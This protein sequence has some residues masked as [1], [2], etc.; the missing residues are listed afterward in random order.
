MGACYSKQEDEDN[1]VGENPGTNL[2]DYQPQP[3][4][5]SNATYLDSRSSKV[6]GEVMISGTANDINHIPGASHIV[7]GG[8]QSQPPVSTE[9]VYQ[10]MNQ[11]IL[12][13]DV[14]FQSPLQ[15]GVGVSTNNVMQDSIN[16]QTQQ[17]Y[18]SNIGSMVYVSKK[19]ELVDGFEGLTQPETMEI[20]PIV[21]ND[22]K[23]QQEQP[24][25][26]VEQAG[27]VD[28]ANIGNPQVENSNVQIIE[29]YQMGV[30]PKNDLSNIDYQHDET[31]TANKTA[32]EIPGMTVYDTMI[33]GMVTILDD[34]TPV[35]EMEELV[36]SASKPI[37]TYGN[38]P[39][40]EYLQTVQQ[41]GG[42][43][44]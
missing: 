16:E 13:T 8:Y 21:L 1:I 33:G 5:D 27:L 2:V 25:F 29:N 36:I 23:E 30:V 41:N 18:D 9:I 4:I 38:I 22:R 19:N 14:V 11:P 24:M 35:E 34:K 20:K 37:V 28:G 10:N 31:Q 42:F 26:G 39:Q 44:V 40:Q 12:S 6:G 17:V 15:N 43:A 32:N 3:V 7:N